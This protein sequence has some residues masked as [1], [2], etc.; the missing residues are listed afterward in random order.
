[1]EA[2]VTERCIKLDGVLGHVL[3]LLTERLEG[4]LQLVT[5]LSFGLLGGQVIAIVHVL[6]L[7][8]VGGD[9]TYLGVEL[10]VALLLLSKHDCVL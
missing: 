3:D 8:Q 1:M 4:L 2:K 6:V 7:A 5:H 10:N 9:L